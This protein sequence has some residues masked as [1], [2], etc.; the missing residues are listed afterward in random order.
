M[1][2]LICTSGIHATYYRYFYESYTHYRLRTGNADYVVYRQCREYVQSAHARAPRPEP[3][4]MKRTTQLHGEPRH[5]GM[6][7]QHGCRAHTDTHAR[8]NSNNNNHNNNL[9]NNNNNNNSAAMS[10]QDQLQLNRAT[11][12][13][14]NTTASS[15]LAA[16]SV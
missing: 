4:R 9:N 6:R 15:Q 16:H 5:N 10:S 14:S 7:W 2:Y 13:G 11:H 1:L 12:R 3:P 8:D